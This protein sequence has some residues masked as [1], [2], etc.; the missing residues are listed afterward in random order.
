MGD[1]FPLGF[2][3]PTAGYLPG[4]RGDVTLCT[5]FVAPPLFPGFHL[6]CIAVIGPPTRLPGIRR[7]SLL[8]QP[9][10]FE[11]FLRVEILADPNHLATLELHDPSDCRFGHCAAL[12]AASPEV[13]DGDDSVAQVPD[14]C[15]L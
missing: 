15:L 9:D 4:W 10:G 8:P 11:G 13:T 1:T 7:L 2:K 3:Q 5:G 6:R 14:L 12:I